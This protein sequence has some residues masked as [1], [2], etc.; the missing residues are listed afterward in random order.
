MFL[1][2]HLAVML[3][4][5]CLLT[6]MPNVSSGQDAESIRRQEAA[7]W[8]AVL[9]SDASLHE[10]AMACR[11]LAVAGDKNA[12]KPLAALLVDPKLATYARS[13]LEAIPDTSADHALR[14]AAGRLDGPLLVGVL[15]SIGKRRD[16]DAIDVLA[17]HL[18]S[19]DRTV[20]AA[21]A[22][23]LG[24]IGNVKTA[25]ILRKTL[26]GAAADFRPAA[27]TACLI[28]AQRLAQHGAKNRAIA[29]YDNLRGADLPEHLVL[30][31][32][33]GKILAQGND[34]LALLV[35]Q[36]ASADDARFRLA[37]QAARQLGTAASAPLIA[38]FEKETP[39]RQELLVLALIDIADK[40]ALPIFLSAAQSGPKNVR[41]HA[42]GALGRLGDSAAAAVLL[43]A[44]LAGDA[45]VARVA[46]EALAVLR[47]S[48]LN[49]TIA[50]M[51]DERKPRAVRL[52]VILAGQRGIASATPALFRLA[53]HS[54]MAIRRA[55]VQSLGSTISLG[56]LPKLIDLA[57][58]PE[59]A[60]GQ[61]VARAA[62]KAACAR[63]PR[64]ACAEKLSAAMSGAST[65]VKV[66]LLEQLAAIGGKQALDT[67][68]AAGR[69][70]DDAMQDAA[71][72]LLGG[73][74]SADAAPQLLGLVKTLTSNKYKVRALRGYIRIARQ[75]D[76]T[77]A[78]RMD[79]CRNALAIAD[80]NAEKILVLQTLGRIGSPQALK[81]AAGLL[82]DKQLR[83]PACLAI[84]TI[85]DRAAPLA[86]R[87]TV[88]ALQQVLQLTADQAIR[89][90]ARQQLEKARKLPQQRR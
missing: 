85:A 23:A 56:D 82:K 38:R 70:D 9:N 8:T 67:V 46:A 60:D 71:T 30:A 34:G 79:V 18:G 66:S 74:L 65:P 14:E 48:Q 29:L 51:L 44:A 12:V 15:G 37:L 54:D 32:T 1:P 21:A 39:R 22:R 41:L 81:L 77:P 69:S 47:S 2:R 25:D 17:G 36:L 55:A 20:A 76:M 16:T 10:K 84:V 63:L 28:C 26:A 72:R 75:L 86:P 89:Q 42:I 64:E 24:E 50:Q 78:E 7:R 90:R 80:R 61:G 43:K 33:L 40:K 53:N 27:A 6:I 35:E 11:R 57:G 83:E 45:E 73:W 59:T 5:S 3:V 87:D 19:T 58:Q 52:A 31:A 68:A 4:A 49:A 88:Q 62:L 13:A